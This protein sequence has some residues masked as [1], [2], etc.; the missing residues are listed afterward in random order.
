[1]AITFPVSDGFRLSTVHDTL[2]FSLWIGLFPV[3]LTLQHSAS[4]PG[5]LHFASVQRLVSPG[6]VTMLQLHE[7]KQALRIGPAL[8][9]F[10]VR[11]PTVTSPSDCPRH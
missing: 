7:R 3:D 4:Y 2:N 10:V 6:I 5:A 8:S 9:C 1:M 11:V